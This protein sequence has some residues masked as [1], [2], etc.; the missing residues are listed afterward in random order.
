MGRIVI[1]LT[2]AVLL[3][4]SWRLGVALWYFGMRTSTPGRVYADNWF[5]AWRGF[6]EAKPD[7]RRGFAYPFVLLLR[8]H[9]PHGSFVPKAPPGYLS[10]KTGLSLVGGWGLFRKCPFKNEPNTYLLMIENW[11]RLLLGTWAIY[12]ALWLE[13]EERAAVPCIERQ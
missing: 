11:P 7:G 9:V 1:S 6:T 8:F 12:N 13:R 5:Y 4:I 10:D 2:I 3:I